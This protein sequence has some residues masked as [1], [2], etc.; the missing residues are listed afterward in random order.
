MNAITYDERK[1]VYQEAIERYGVNHQLNKFDEELGEFLAEYGRMRNGEGDRDKFAEELG[2]LSIMLEQ[3]RLIFGV[4]D[5]VCEHMDMKIRRLVERLSKCD[6]ISAA[7]RHFEHGI[8]HDIFS[9]PVTSFAR[10]AIDALKEYRKGREQNPLTW[11]DLLKRIGKPVWIRF[12][13][14]SGH[15]WIVTDY[16]KLSRDF[17][18]PGSKE[19]Y[20]ETWVAFDS[21]V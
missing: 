8:S 6:D 21:E 1:A 4:N 16:N 17:F 11:E 13:D 9:E 19:E 10:M 20:G 15:W 5:L 7:I 2:D 14:G 12:Q 3:M 18:D